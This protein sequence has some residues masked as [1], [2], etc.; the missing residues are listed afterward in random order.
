[1]NLRRKK[2][3]WAT[4]DTGTLLKSFLIFQAV[5]GSAGCPESVTMALTVTLA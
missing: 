1:M 4:E 3:I 5:L 2:E